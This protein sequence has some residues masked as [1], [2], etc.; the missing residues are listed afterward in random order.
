[1]KTTL[2]DVFFVLLAVSGGMAMLAGN[3]QAAEEPL[4]PEVKALIGMKVSPVVAGRTPG[5]IP[6]FIKSNGSGG[7]RGADIYYEFGV[8]ASKWPVLLVERVY[9]DRAIE[10]LNIQMLPSSLL[11]WRFVRGEFIEVKGRFHLS[12][13]CKANEEDKRIIVG[14]MTPVVA[15]SGCIHLRSKLVKRAWQIDE[16]DGQVT[17]ISPQSLQCVYDEGGENECE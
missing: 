13:Y 16:Q 2:R 9:E 6:N 5:V 1:M 15:Q 10:I 8:V 3:A 4:P 17:A 7:G 12:P 14:L 11:D